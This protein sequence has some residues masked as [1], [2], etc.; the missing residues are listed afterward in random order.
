VTRGTIGV[1]RGTIF[2]AFSGDDMEVH[3]LT[4]TIRMTQMWHGRTMM[5]QP[6]E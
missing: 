5:W 3:M 1:T 6:Y 2:L 4:W